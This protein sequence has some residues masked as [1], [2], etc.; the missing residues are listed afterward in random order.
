MSP[1]VDPIEHAVNSLPPF[2]QRRMAKL[3]LAG[4]RFVLESNGIYAWK[5][6]IG[7]QL[8]DRYMYLQ[9][10]IN[11]TWREWLMSKSNKDADTEC[12]EEN[13]AHPDKVERPY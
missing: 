8:A 12:W 10:A 7:D 9:S 1:D 4:A 3:S 11:E 2:M 5:V 6:M 13:Y